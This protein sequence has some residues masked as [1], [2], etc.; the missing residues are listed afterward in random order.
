MANGPIKL[1]VRTKNSIS[2][3]ETT[4]TRNFNY[5]KEEVGGAVSPTPTPT[6]SITPTP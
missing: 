3:R 2:G 4:Y 5:Q 6:I 1:E